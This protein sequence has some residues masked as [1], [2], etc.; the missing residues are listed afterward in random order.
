MAKGFNLTAQINL[1]GPANLKPVIAQ[2]RKELGT[3]SADVKLNIDARS[4]KSVDAITSKL[5]AMNSVLVQSKQNVDSLNSSFRTL[6][7]ALSTS[8]SDTNK[9]TSSINKTAES[10]ASA[11]KTVHQAGT[12]MEEFGKQ[13]FLAIKR[14]AAF[15]FVTTGIFALT[16]A[17]TGGFRAFINFDKELVKLQQVTGKGASGIAALEKEITRLATTMGVS[18]ES[19]INVA[20]TLAQA[21]L[22]ADETRTALEALA[23]TELAPSFDNLTDTTEGAIAAMRQFG[24]EAG[25][26]ESALGSINAVAA[27]YAVESKD[28]ISAIQRTGGVF[29][30]ASKGVSQGTDALNEFIAIFT[31][32][33][34]TTRESAE[35]IAT[36]LRTIFT[37][38]QRASTIQQLKEFGVVLTDLEGKFVGPYEAIKRLS[39][40]L[41]KLDPRDLRFSQI[42]E[43]LGGFRQI[44]KV[45]P[46]IQQFATAQEALKVAQ[47]GQ[48][49]LTEAQVVAQQSL[50]NQLAKVREQFLAL[51]RDVGKS[52]VFQGLFKVV[53]GLASAMISLAGAFKPILPILAVMGAIKG[54]SA[55]TQFATGFFGGMSKGGGAKAMGQS[56]GDGISGAKEKEKAEATNRASQA[57][58]ENTGAIRTLTTAI[59][60]LTTRVDANTS[61]INSRGTSTLRSGGKVLGF[62]KGG[63]V[64]GY[65]GG[66]RVPALLEGGE[67]V[68]NKRAVKKYGAGNLTRMNNYAYG[69]PIG[70]IIKKFPKE[71]RTATQFMGS[72][73]F[74]KG[75]PFVESDD[76]FYV[77]IIPEDIQIDRTQFPEIQK[78]IINLIPSGKR[79]KSY[80]KSFD[81]RSGPVIEDWILQQLGNKWVRKYSGKKINANISSDISNAPID[82]ESKNPNIIGEVKFKNQKSSNNELLGK[83]L[84]YRLENISDLFAKSEFYKENIDNKKD[85][86]NVIKLHYYNAANNNLKNNFMEWIRSK[87]KKSNS[88]KIDTGVDSTSIL[89]R[90][91]SDLDTHLLRDGGLVQKFPNGGAVENFSRAEIFKILSRQEAAEAAGIDVF[92]AYD[93]MG[94][95]RSPTEKEKLWR[96][97]IQSAYL[98]KLKDQGILE[99]QAINKA[100]KVGIVGLQPFDYSDTDG[101]L[102]LGGKSIFMTI[103]GL[104]AKF[105]DRVAKMRESIENVVRDFATG[106]QQT[107]IFGGGEQLRLDFDETLVSGADIF[108]SN[109]AIDIAGYSDLDRVKEALSRGRLTQL[110]EKIKEI[111]SL[112]PS[113]ADRISVLTA[114]PQSNAKLLSDK[115]NQLGLPIPASKITGTSGGGKAKA[116]ALGIAEKLIDDNLDNI[117]AAKSQGKSALQYSEIRKLSDTEKAA[118]GFANIE[119]AVLESTLAALGARGGSIQNRAIDYENGLG[120]AAQYFPGIGPDWPTEVK[121]TLD[122]TS[123]GRAKEEFSRFYSQKF[124]GGG[125]ISRKVPF[126]RGVG[127]SPFVTAKVKK[128]GPEIYDLEKDSGL[129][130]F[131][132]NDVVDFARTNDFNFEEFKKY[133][134]ERIAQK[135][136][137]SNLMMNPID[138]LRGITPDSSYVSQK[139]RDL[140]QSLMGEADAKYN[141]KYDN[142]RKGFSVFAEGGDVKSKEKN[143]GK[144]GLRSSGSEITANYMS[145]SERSGFVTAKK[146]EGDLYT[147]GLSKA[148]K[149]YGPRLY[150]VVMEAVT[151]QGGMLTSD[152]NQVSDSARAVWSFYFNRRSDVKKTPLDPSQWTKNQSYIDPKLYGRKET[153]PPSDDPAWILQSGYSKNPELINSA[154]IINLN[155]PKYTDF[156]RK[157]QLNF[158]SRRGG[159][160]IP[161]R[162]SNGEAFV[163]PKLAKKIGYSKLNKLNQ[164]DRNGMGFSR[165][166]ISI[167]KGPGSGTSDS[168]STSLPVGGY[169]I[170]EK[171]T[172]ALGLYK[173]GGSIN[174]PKFADGGVLSK[175]EKK[176]RKD[177]FLTDQRGGVSREEARAVGAPRADF[178]GATVD[179]LADVKQSAR[180]RI[181]K[182]AE[183]GTVLPVNMG[184]EQLVSTG[185]G[186]VSRQRGKTYTSEQAKEL[187]AKTSK[188][189]TEVNTSSRKKDIEATANP[190]ELDAIY[191]KIENTVLNNYKKLYAEEKKKIDDLYN[192]RR[193]EISDQIFSGTISASEGFDK[194]GELDNE[195][196]KSKQDVKAKLT[197]E[198]KTAQ[199][200]AVEDFKQG[201]QTTSV[202]K[203]KTEQQDSFDVE[204]Q[205]A[206]STVAE[207]VKKKY[208]ALLDQEVVSL[209]SF[210]NERVKQVKAEGGDVDA[211]VSEYRAAL[212][213]AKKSFELG[214][215]TETAEKQAA[216]PEQVAQSKR[217]QL[218]TLRSQKDPF[219]EAKKAADA[220]AAVMPGMPRVNSG[221]AKENSAYF[222]RR[223]EKAG[224]SVGGY[225]YSLAQQVGEQAYNIR[226]DSK[227]AKD[228]AKDIAIGKSRELKGLNVKPGE[229]KQ[230]LSEGATSDEAK[231]AQAAVA[232]FAT[233]L[234]K[235]APSMDPKEIKAAAASLAEGLAAGDKSLEEL[236]AGNEE[237][238]KVFA[239]T[240]SEGEALDEAFKRVAESAGISAETIKA[241]VSPQQIKQQE[242]IKSQAGQRFGGL[243]SFA[244]GLTE[245]FS[246]TKLG[247]VLGKGADFVSGKGGALSKAFAGAGGF[248]GIGMGLATGAETLKQFLPKTM[249]S[250]PNTAG[251]LGAL[252]GAGTGAAAGAQLGSLAGPV[253]ALIGGVGGA[254]I[255]GI[256]GFF[257]AKN[258]A[259]LTNAL[260][261]IAKKSGDLEIAFKKLETNFT[262]ANFE[263][264][265]K[266]FGEVL[267][268][269]KDVRDMAFSSPSI[270]GNDAM[271]IGGMTLAGAG[272]GAAVGALAGKWIG[273][274]LGGAAGTAAAPGAGTAAGAVG[275]SLAGAGI[276]ATIGAGIGGLAGAAYGFFNRPSAEQ[277]KEALGATIQQAGIQNDT[278]I[279]LA[280]SQLKTMSA[281]DIDK[282]FK[283]SNP[284]VEQYKKGMKGATAAQAEEAAALDAFMKL[285]KQSGATD[286]QIRKEIES[287]RSAAIAKGKE[288]NNAQAEALKKQALLAIATKQVALATESLL[289]VYRRVTANA[290]RFSDEVGDMLSG[291]QASIS[292]LGGKA[293]VPKVDRRGSERVLGNISAYS[294]DE[295]KVATQDVVS[296]LG[297]GEEAQKLGKQAEAAKFL[298]DKLPAM[299]RAP[300]ADKN[301]IIDSIRT[302]FKGMG[303]DSNAINAMIQDI[304]TEIAKN[305]DG[306]LGTLASDIEKGGIGSISS[307]SQEALKTL[308]NLSKT[309]NDT[310]QESINLQNQYNEVIM[311]SEEYMRKAGTIRISAELD[312]A[313][314]LGNSPTLAQLNEPFNFEVRDLTKG[315]IPG[316]TTD[317]AQIAAGIVSATKENEI[318]KDKNTQ[319]NSTPTGADGQA[320][321]NAL[322]EQQ[323]N[324]AAMSANSKAINQGRQA[325]EKLAN[326]GTKAANALAKIE[327]NERIYEGGRSLGR[328][329]LTSDSQQLYEMNK[330]LAAYTKTISGKANAK[331]ANSLQFRK[332]AFAGFDIVKN[333]MPQGMSKKIEA[334]LQKEMIEAMPEGQQML[335]QQVGIGNNDK[336]ITLRD[337][338][339]QAISGEANEEDPNVKAYR[340]AVDTQIKANEQL[341]MLNELQALKIQESMIGL[342][343]F[344]ANK[345]P[346]ILTKAVTASREDAATKPEV[347]SGDAK[348]ESG[349]K[350]QQTE[351]EIV[352]KQEEKTKL[353]KEIA[354]I[355][356]QLEKEKK[357]KWIDQDPAKIAKLENQKRSAENKR[358]DVEFGI[359]NRQ[360]RL[361]EEKAAEKQELAQVK[362][363]EETKKKEKE[364]T[365][366]VVVSAERAAKQQEI[367]DKEKQIQENKD[368]QASEAQAST[369]TQTS[370]YTVSRPATSTAAASASQQVYGSTRT[371]A[372]KGKP[373][374]T[375]EPTVKE[376]ENKLKGLR[377]Q[378]KKGRDSSEYSQTVFMLDRKK[379]EEKVIKDKVKQDKLASNK[380]RALGAAL[381][382]YKK[383]VEDGTMSQA[384]FDTKKAEYD[385]LKEQ[386]KAQSYTSK[387]S[388]PLNAKQ[389]AYIDAKKQRREAYLSRFRPEVREKMMTKEEKAERDAQVA[390]AE[391]A[392]KQAEVQ[393][394]EQKANEVIM[395]SEEYIRDKQRS[396]P[397]AVSS[398]TTTGQQPPVPPGSIPS[399]TEIWQGTGPISSSPVPVVRPLD[400]VPASSNPTTA[401]SPSSSVTA[402]TLTIDSSSLKS[403]S[404]FNNNFNSYVTRLEQ[405]EFKPIQH[406]VEI[407]VQPIQVQI[408]GASAMEGLSKEMQRV[409]EA[410][411]VPRIQALRD[412]ISKNSNGQLIKP[413]A[414]VGGGSKSTGDISK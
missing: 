171:A 367:A 105:A 138:L 395:R 307:T 108:D 114:R 101:P 303:L 40:G 120:P 98:T 6:S 305:Q 45:I 376:L 69:G 306:N 339:D 180:E 5:R 377:S 281:E 342:Q 201:K 68:I 328:T 310:L 325:L 74:S 152:R 345:F 408:T 176:R 97:A 227:F 206:M 107:E 51:I 136:A 350:R 316:G 28:I 21:G 130:K 226:Q 409:A 322:K 335:D 84:R 90:H 313:K 282:T 19:L 95:R 216:V 44:G 72:K 123:I 267:N 353:D 184:E 26:L 17:I 276:G 318:L 308:Q 390:Q 375:T 407:N 406:K 134:Q 357:K 387:S 78:R 39:E 366:P 290:Q 20:S 355:D 94:L 156:I 218:D 271:S 202:N 66:D 411:I 207:E 272:T 124:A 189:S 244:P 412:E 143:Y 338:L 326:D 245:K 221:I 195:R 205:T 219:Y 321:A 354:N 229:F 210:Y 185:S 404:E 324:N 410:M 91:K 150:D 115:L 364:A 349:K 12:A 247:G 190:K 22:S 320:A 269:Q 319:L 126:E 16:N 378:G 43:E 241:N 188:G 117:R 392:K 284:I 286:E 347:S 327:E 397:N 27:A 166:G 391:E 182:A 25:Q 71:S 358:K 193:S 403:L 333:L 260:E 382:G 198:T 264:A 42:V 242:F 359:K 258:Q 178:G 61:A 92:K 380:T 63:L 279:R 141:P 161:A 243:A 383:M 163:A 82:L 86:D 24:L 129:S 203:R 329:V 36:G 331:N 280:E 224:M 119:G 144:I 396:R 304:E 29:A 149:G 139:Q 135:K 175:A 187:V 145:N 7:S 154:D 131:E 351:Q 77:D 385:T 301:Q 371:A 346:E 399:P 248:T 174:V 81:A 50:A 273:G 99:T 336:K 215:K 361:E 249:T 96:D 283:D 155:D 128:L 37:R 363:E 257:N 317:P 127:P 253:G 15:S 240:I 125:K 33:R 48:G 356:T 93:V 113:F 58:S 369:Q 1:R 278:A 234:Q 233:S 252:G 340:E 73:T 116:D 32:V 160:S 137:K 254:I 10:A 212:D 352:S 235:I 223:A 158:L 288:Y 65:G 151:S 330:S 298:Q 259:I 140:A 365:K 173:N 386:Q 231:K 112:D 38:I 157:Q 341:S 159:G 121:R 400:A 85:I 263:N 80:D 111:L 323:K 239:Y 83:A 196:R 402:Q 220:S 299:L 162:V 31:S 46:L 200:K 211:V 79:G 222:A 343:E 311:Q 153:W 56:A 64:P 148:T 312:L 314:A 332:D 172:K 368:K 52:T 230:L 204:I 197:A 250:D 388:K 379:N 217:Q 334:R 9:A 177:A 192:Q 181:V 104:S 59:N 294:S 103:S 169:V 268:A 146:T 2:I 142:A 186:T 88:D 54:V 34:Q 261:N 362:Q 300:D 389:Q 118:A 67:V 265:Q 100:T 57:I 62:N 41:S 393:A 122:S 236:I 255:G 14:F 237:L 405:L 293:E 76:E 106:I 285:R 55:I 274:L 168:I 132:F 315:L 360:A 8:Q 23:K 251:A 3:V 110:G 270:T 302:Q 179:V 75:R 309:Y 295:V 47:K 30:T 199:V 277:R 164:A 413:T 165:G 102:N 370:T 147:I 246:K 35:T 13:S 414:A 372:A 337:V 53:T 289:D 373:E 232:E 49:S 292:S 194:I 291:A 296:K 297:G 183:T 18:S 238:S 381:P 133:L 167:F 374:A 60:N 11:A 394:Q 256:Q 213:K 87:Q 191:K 275:G 4:I 262:K 398:T 266:Q 109:G 209:K 228:E 70:K 287:G 208:Q 225:K 170:R 89:G 214:R 348:T 344:L 384:D 401:S